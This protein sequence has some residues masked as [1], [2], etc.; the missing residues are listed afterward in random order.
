MASSWNESSGAVACA[1]LP[2][3]LRPPAFTSPGTRVRAW[4]RAQVEA[5]KNEGVE[6]GKARAQE[7]VDMFQDKL[8]ETSNQLQA[9]RDK[10]NVRTPLPALLW[11]CN[12]LPL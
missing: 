11:L 5:A 7:V 10:V 12:G 8:R 1:C 3:G 2:C 6:K 9:E 4:C